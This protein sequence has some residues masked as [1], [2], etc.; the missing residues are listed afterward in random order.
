MIGAVSVLCLSLFPSAFILIVFPFLHFLFFC[1]AFGSLRRVSSLYIES[2][3]E[4]GRGGREG[5]GLEDIQQ[6]IRIPAR[7]SAARLQ[8]LLASHCIA[9]MAVCSNS[10]GYYE[11]HRPSAT[12]GTIT[13]FHSS[14]LLTL[15]LCFSLFCCATS[16]MYKR[17]LLN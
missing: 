9:C 7:F 15:S 10:Q 1:P 14:S 6:D 8:S 17:I 12:C 11:P 2:V 3:A 4:P 5:G 16:C 13:I